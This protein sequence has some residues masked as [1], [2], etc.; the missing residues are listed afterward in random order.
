MVVVK[1]TKKGRQPFQKLQ[2]FG[3]KDRAIV[4]ETKEGILFKPFPDISEE[5]GSLRKLFRKGAREI[6]E[7]ARKKDIQREKMLER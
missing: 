3:F 1:I 4:F 2:K 5:K 7:E 6:I